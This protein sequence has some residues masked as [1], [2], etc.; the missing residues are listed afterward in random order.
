MNQQKKSFSS[1]KWRSKGF[2]LGILFFVIV[3][4][5][6]LSLLTAFLEDK[7]AL[8]QD[9]SYNA[10]T[11][12]SPTTLA[13]VQSIQEPVEIFTV[14]NRGQEDAQLVDLIA[15]YQKE[16]PFISFELIVPS[17]NP[18][19]IQRYKDK[20][21]DLPLDGTLI[22]STTTDRYKVL[23]PTDYIIP[24][25]NEELEIEYRYQYEKV[26]SEALVYVTANHIP[27]ALFVTGHQE[28]VQ[29]QSIAP[30]EAMLSANHFSLSQGAITN[31]PD[32][33]NTDLLFI[34][35]P[36]RDFT[37][38]EIDL[39]VDYL[40]KGGSLFV[41]LDPIFHEESPDQP[42]LPN[43][44]SLLKS[45]GILPTQGTILANK[46]STDDYSVNS[47][48][49]KPL[50]AEQE[51]LSS[52]KEQGFTDI[53]LPYT[54][55]F[56]PPQEVDE[57]LLVENLL[58]SSSSSYEKILTENMEEF[59]KNPED[60]EGPF[61]LA[62]LSTKEGKEGHFG[63]IL[64]LGTSE[65]LLNPDIL[66]YSHNEAFFHTLLSSLVPREDFTLAISSKQGVRPPLSQGSTPMGV[67]LVVLLPV[68]VLLGALL[69]LL[70]RKHL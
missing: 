48:V 67:A 35:S 7:Y 29:S 24:Q 51:L 55:G 27:T 31:N 50:L 47:F 60:R 6:T 30:L 15:R 70:P 8:K 4:A 21:E 41:T 26:L 57:K 44:M 5:V 38:E 54:T 62:L 1:S 64:A 53:L 33:F 36:T 39:T 23:A 25:Y 12:L 46:E 63:K 19:F 40:S 52:L 16:N 66:Y 14:A 20:G 59:E 13:V 28:I 17:E 32:L 45:Y 43:L 9:F 68:L 10:I 61:A 22:R 42:Y 49:L 37:Q 34:L 69:I 65:A 56:F 2:S 18:G 11:T 58:N 3:I